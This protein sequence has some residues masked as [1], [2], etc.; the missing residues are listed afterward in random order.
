M[1]LAQARRLR[2]AFQNPM[3]RMLALSFILSSLYLPTLL[4]FMAQHDQRLISGS[5]NDQLSAAEFSWTGK[6]RNSGLYLEFL[7]TNAVALVSSDDV[8]Y[9]PVNNISCMHTDLIPT[10][11]TRVFDLVCAPKYE[12]WIWSCGAVHRS[13]AWCW[14]IALH[15]L[16]T[17]RNFWMMEMSCCSS[18]RASS[19]NPTALQGTFRDAF[20]CPFTLSGSN[21]IQGTKVSNEKCM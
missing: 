1:A 8:S 6:R 2:A 7:H 18:I 11:G 4:V 3:N 19:I 5:F 17:T 9:P 16:A 21:C 20:I 13:C 12:S 10:N 15:G 14:R